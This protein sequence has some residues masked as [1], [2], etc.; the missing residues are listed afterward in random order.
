M[1]YFSYLS[2]FFLRKNHRRGVLRWWVR[3]F[4][5]PPRRI[6]SFLE[7]AC[8]HTIYAS[9]V[10]R[11][12]KYFK[13]SAFSLTCCFSNLSAAIIIFKTLIWFYHLTFLNS[14]DG[15]WNIII[16]INVSNNNNTCYQQLWNINIAH[17][18][19]HRASSA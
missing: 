19:I 6:I 8:F 4:L 15:T 3:Y 12:C 10:L 18:S 11:P 2:I 7:F 13:T 16:R 1:F 17:R 14:G 5:P 9:F